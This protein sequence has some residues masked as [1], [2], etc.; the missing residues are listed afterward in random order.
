MARTL[1]QKR[2]EGW[3]ILDERTKRLDESFTDFQRQ[4]QS[5][6]NVLSDIQGNLRRMEGEGVTTKLERSDNRCFGD[7]DNSLDSRMRTQENWKFKVIGIALGAG[8]FSGLLTG[9]IMLLISKRF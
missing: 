3:E 9:L 7:H 2:A 6:R 1:D 4:Y 5:D 8:A